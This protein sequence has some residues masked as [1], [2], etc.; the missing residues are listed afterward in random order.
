MRRL[1]PV[2]MAAVLAA[3]GCSHPVLAASR[4]VPGP[5]VT[6]SPSPN[7]PSPTPVPSTSDCAAPAVAVT[8][9]PA[10]D[11]GPFGVRKTTGSAAVA[12]TFDD[13]P[14]PVN[15]PLILDVLREC[16]VKA[17]FCLVGYKVAM[18]PDVV[19]RIVADGHTLC[20]H[21][22]EHIRQLGTY[23]QPR[24]RQDLQQTIDAIHAAAPGAPVS[25]FRAPGGAWTKDYVTV[26]HA[27]GHDAD[28][29]GRGSLGL[30]HRPVRDVDR[31]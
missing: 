18:Y 29:L 11:V 27:H 21:T 7:T 16:G 4:R 6:Q 15:T 13:G 31:R 10:T 17:T 12:L 3:A 30:E 28:R 8:A 19:R 14:D 25:Y 5:S 23:G 24:I 22:W 9:A 1:V 2:A 26:A 20:D